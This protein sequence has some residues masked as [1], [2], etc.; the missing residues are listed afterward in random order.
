M[1]RF[2]KDSHNCYPLCT[3]TPKTGSYHLTQKDKRPICSQG[4]IHP[5]ALWVPNT[6][7]VLGG[8]MK[9]LKM[10]CIYHAMNSGLPTL[11]RRPRCARAW[12]RG[13]HGLGCTGR[14]SEGLR[15]RRAGVDGQFALPSPKRPKSWEGNAA[16]KCSMAHLPWEVTCHV[17]RP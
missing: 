17:G 15:T 10:A 14:G 6:T 3:S 4:S 13:G 16:T 12:G 1:H 8:E 9:V 7:G 5:E 2:P 11:G